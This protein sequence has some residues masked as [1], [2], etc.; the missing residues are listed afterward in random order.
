MRD[1]NGVASFYLVQHMHKG[2]ERWATSGGAQF[3]FEDLPYF[4]AQGLQGD[5]YR[6]LHDPT[7][8]VWQDTGEHEGYETADQAWA[9]V[10]AI[11]GRKHPRH[12][13]I[14]FRVVHRTIEQHTV[15]VERPRARA[16]A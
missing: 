4:S 7:H 10:D 12:A 3:L 1:E 15:R 16:A 5:V 11:R 14:K 6:A 8:R 9:V 2:E 13:D